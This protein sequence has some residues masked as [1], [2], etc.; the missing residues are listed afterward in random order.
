MHASHLVPVAARPVPPMFLF[1]V[2]IG[3]PEFQL[4]STF[5]ES[6][7]NRAPDWGPIGYITYKRTYSRYQDPEVGGAFRMV[8]P[9]E[10]EEWWQTVARVVEGTYQIQQR[11][12][13]VNSIP[14]D[15]QKAVNSAQEMYERMFSFKFTPP[16]RGL[17]MMGTPYIQK[18]GSAALN[19]CAF[20]S[21]KDIDSDFAEPFTFLMDLSM[22]GV[23]V[24]SDTRG[25]SKL[26]IKGIN[27]GIPTRKFLIPD[28]REGWVQAVRLLL[29]AYAYGKGGYVF[30]YSAIRPEGSPI[31]G[32]GGVASGPGPLRQLLEVD[33]PHILDAVRGK[34][35]RSGTI[36]DLHNA[37]GRCVVSGNVRR[38]AEIIFGEHDDDEFMNLKNWNVAGPELGWWRWN[39]N[40]SIFA[41]RG[42]DYTASA[43]RTATFGDPGY[44][45]LDLIQAYGRLKDQPTWVDSRVIG[46]NPCVEQSLEHRE[47]CCLVETYPANHTSAEDYLRTLK[48][49][50]LYA[51]TV[52]CLPTHLPETNAVL[53]R[54]RRIGCSQSGIVQN[55]HKLGW[56]KHMEWS[57][58]G[59]NELR[60]L[61]NVYSEWLCIPRSVKV[62]SV[63]PSGTVSLLCG[64]TPGIHYPI[65]EYC[66]RR[67]TFKNDHPLLKEL[68]RCGYPT[69]PSKS[70]PETTTM[71][72]FPVKWDSFSRA[73]GDVSMWQQL[74]AAAQMQFEWSDNQVSC[75][76][77][78]DP[79]REGPDIA[80]A[81][82]MYEGRLKG[83]SFLANKDHGH[84]QAPWEPIDRE[85]YERRLSEL[86]PLGTVSGDTA[87][88]PEKF[89][90]GD[91]CSVI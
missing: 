77:K 35:I 74:E 44:L 6:Y 51:K 30:D 5:L 8:A 48:F 52:T 73:E 17:W 40:N 68:I 12:C 46:A 29:E 57:D 21:T 71:V 25:T 4:D 84:A 83:I 47:L 89:C 18:H 63:K 45:W 85:E 7:R 38:S 88:A 33:I 66:V 3:S 86:Q 15:Y 9:G 27:T 23:G 61:D 75:T 39:S 36:T 91:K 60:R 55:V 90:D 54:N 14:W 37:I 53:L 43:E 78:F 69:E 64:A 28:T 2:D 26:Y 10:S 72:E 67:M 19:N 22:L 56:R 58:R 65:G 49:A 50:Y 87:D 79:D 41:M 82:E 31:R 59:Y 70:S 76:I 34:L 42:M 11:H 24:G 62:S 13:A 32:F 20:I 1:S 80:R 81:L 16:G